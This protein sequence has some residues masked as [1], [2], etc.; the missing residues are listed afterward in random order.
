VPRKDKTKHQEYSL[1]RYHQR[2]ANAIEFLGGQCVK[3]KSL[4]R[5]E[6]DHINPA[7]KSFHVNDKISG[8]LDTL[9]PELL[10][11]QLLCHSCHMQKTILERGDK[12]SQHGST[13]MY[14]HGCR[15]QSCKAANAT[16]WQKYKAK[17]RL[18]ATKK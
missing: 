14:G 8:D 9:M 4:D 10:K 6:F 5:L 7:T 12:P 18:D 16:Y 3:C 15:C 13:T 17:K 11:C 1:V 2:R